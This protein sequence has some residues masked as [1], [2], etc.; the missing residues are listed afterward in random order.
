M[1]TTIVNAEA[2]SEVVEIGA[3]I[4]D[5]REALGYQLNDVAAQLHI[6]IAHLEAI[7]AGRL[8][9]LPGAVYVSGFLRAYAGLLGLDSDEILLRLKT[10]GV[11]IGKQQRLDLLSPVE[12]GRLP[13]GP[14]FLLAIVIAL[15]AY[16]GWHYLYSNERG[17]LQTSGVSG[18]GPGDGGSSD[19]SS[20]AVPARTPDVSPGGSA[21]SVA[22]VGEKGDPGPA[23]QVSSPPPAA[24]ETSP[25]QAVGAPPPSPAD[26]SRPAASPQAATTPAPLAPPDRTDGSDADDGAVVDAAPPE[27]AAAETRAPPPAPPVRTSEAETGAVPAGDGQA[28]RIVVRAIAN[29][30]VQ[31]LDENGNALYSEMMQ[32]GDA[33]EAPP[34]ANLLL[35]TGNAGGLRVVVDGRE[36]PLLGSVGEVL[37]GISLDRGLLDR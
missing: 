11:N 19:P 10:S 9:D 24:A 28:A 30:Y 23:S 35:D 14:I 12:E 13:T 29:S 27:S 16:G 1:N 26:A 22:E 37:R 18:S 5:A 31:V 32:A 8:S 7:E 36:A 17:S 33:Y 2:Q 25:A 34:G 3:M 15:A 20:G 4:R 6:R 21:P